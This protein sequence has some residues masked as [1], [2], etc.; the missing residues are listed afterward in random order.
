MRLIRTFLAVVL[1]MALVMGTVHSRTLAAPQAKQTAGFDAAAIDRAADPCTDFYQYACGAWMK[2]NAIPADQASWGRFNELVE[3]NRETLRGLL[4]KV[5]EPKADRTPPAQ[6]DTAR[7]LGDYYATCIDEASADQLAA[8]PLAEDLDRI[9]KIKDTAELSREVGFLQ[10][11]GIDAFFAFGSEQDFKDSSSVM[12]I[13]DQGGLGLPDRDY[14]FKE[15][16]NF[17][18]QREQYVEHV[19]KMF[20]LAGD[21]EAQAATQAKA[22][23]AI[24]TALAKNALDRVSRRDPNKIYHK[25]SRAELLSLTNTFLWDPYLTSTGAPQ[26]PSINVTEPEFFKGLDTVISTTKIE[27]LKTY[28]RWHTIHAA[29]PLL[30]SAFVNENFD[31]YGRVLTGRK[32]LQPRWK[33]CVSYTDGDLGEA[34][35]QLYVDATFGAEGKRRMLELVGNLDRALQRDIQDL[36]WMTTKTKQQALSKLATFTKKIGYPDRWRDYAAL[37]INRGDLYGNS[38]RANEFEHRR[39]LAKIGKPLDRTEWSMTPPTVNAYYNPLMN[40]IV[41]PAG[42]LQPP[43]FDRSLDEAVNYGAI[44][45][46]I[47]HEM[48]HGFDDQGRQFDKDGNLQDWWTEAD[49]L[50]FTKRATCVKDQYSGYNVVDK[51]NL[52]GEQTLGENVADN[53]GVRIA[54]F[55]LLEAL[56]GKTPA[57]IDGFSA[58]QRFFLGYAQVWC[59]NVRPEQARLEVTTDVHS[60]GRFRVNGVVSNMAQFAKAFGCKAGQPMVR[61]TQCR[62]W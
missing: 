37:T 18:K 59:E 33:R 35:G 31:F 12:A 14:Y 9:A 1:P 45:A 44:G 62:V 47:G 25:L 41:F 56:D 42:I 24:E 11:V 53:G 40:E 60:P 54:H 15:D 50:Q 2:N 58:D 17:V 36:D 4:E 7:K 32:E 16:A 19:R 21:P 27:D 39:Q 57:P 8:K 30:S 61:E 3:R 20:V 26:F 13:A 46:V 6:T 55:A 49:A 10:R 52:N 48:T 5:S 23:M 34:L 38:Q 51:M 43:F 28:L 22:V 29:A